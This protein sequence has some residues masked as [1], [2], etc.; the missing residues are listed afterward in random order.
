MR[1]PARARTHT[2][3]HARRQAE[4]GA[5]GGGGEGEMREEDLVPNQPCLVTLSSRGYVKR[6]SPE[7]F[8]A[9]RRGGKGGFA[10]VCVCV[11]V[12]VLHP[13]DCFF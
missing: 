3:T 6:L 8:E 11:C 1:L 4:E 13:V 10:A 5:G 2:R 7:T 9:Q 12:C